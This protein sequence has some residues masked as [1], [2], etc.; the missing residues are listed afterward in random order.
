MDCQNHTLELVVAGQSRKR[1]AAAEES[2][3]DS[4]YCDST[5]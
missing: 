3:T 2:S 5:E 4:P 1:E